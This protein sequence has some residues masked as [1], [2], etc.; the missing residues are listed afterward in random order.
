MQA[1]NSS[2][3]E[4]PF[5]AGTLNAL[6][7]LHRIHYISQVQKGRSFFWLLQITLPQLLNKA[8]KEQKRQEMSAD[9]PGYVI[10]PPEQIYAAMQGEDLRP[11]AHKMQLKPEEHD[12]LELVI[13]SPLTTSS[14]L[15]S[16]T[17]HVLY[18]YL[19]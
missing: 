19:F 4:K 15:P 14:S 9:E 7:Y 16:S 17:F 5:H 1:Q 2:S 13:I 12:D 18:V 11:H 10:T 8:E 3:R 6:I